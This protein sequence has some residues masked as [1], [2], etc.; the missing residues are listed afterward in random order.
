[1]ATLRENIRGASAI[2]ITLSAIALVALYV[3]H[4][5]DQNI[6][7]VL[8]SPGVQVVYEPQI[9]PTF[10]TFRGRVEIGNGFVVTNYTNIPLIYIQFSCKIGASRGVFQIPLEADKIILPPHSMFHPGIVTYSH[11]GKTEI[12]RAVDIDAFLAHNKVT[13]CVVFEI[14]ENNAR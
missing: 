2:I 6:P 14:G 4:R 1:M 12:L 5:A 10:G 11:D 13:D 7:K 3:V 8:P 9:K